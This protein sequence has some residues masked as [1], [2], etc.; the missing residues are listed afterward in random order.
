MK[1]EDWYNHIEYSHNYRYDNFNLTNHIRSWTT[2][3]TTSAKTTSKTELP[4][5]HNLDKPAQHKRAYSPNLQDLN[6]NAN[7]LCEALNKIL[8]RT[9]LTNYSK[10]GP[11]HAK[12]RSQSSRPTS[13]TD[14]T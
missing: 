12:R 11:H 10:D 2:T 9:R 1:Q 8:T 13:E 3:S 14:F 5:Y 7:I 4:N 6:P